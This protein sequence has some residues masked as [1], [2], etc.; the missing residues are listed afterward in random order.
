MRGIDERTLLQ[1]RAGKVCRP[2]VVA[3]FRAREPRY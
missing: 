3:A 2:A 1:R